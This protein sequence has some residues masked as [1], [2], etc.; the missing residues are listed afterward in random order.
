MSSKENTGN[1][2]SKNNELPIKSLLN[3]KF[4][5]PSDNPSQSPL[6]SATIPKMTFITRPNCVLDRCTVLCL[7][8]PGFQKKAFKH[9]KFFSE[10]SKRMKEQKKN[11]SERPYRG[12]RRQFTKRRVYLAMFF[13][14]S[15]VQKC[16]ISCHFK[17]PEQTKIVNRF[18]QPCFLWFE[19]H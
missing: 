1:L 4:S 9:I 11:K 5:A 7:Y 14:E 18:K 15:E 10:H 16:L 3:C 6:N 17:K 19:Q 13:S 2:I 8:V 12:I